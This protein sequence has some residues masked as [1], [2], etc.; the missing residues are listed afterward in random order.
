MTIRKAEELEFHWIGYEALTF[1]SICIQGSN[2]PFHYDSW[3]LDESQQ[4]Y[5]IDTSYQMDS[6]FLLMSYTPKTPNF[7]FF[8]KMNYMMISAPF[9]ILWFC[10]DF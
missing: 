6:H 10:R 3:I 9:R 4:N 5:S 8:P 7:Y 1:Y 2:I